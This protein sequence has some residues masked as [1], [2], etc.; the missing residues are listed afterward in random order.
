MNV[1][2]QVSRSQC[3]LRI[4]SFTAAEQESFGEFCTARPGRSAGRPSHV[5]GCRLREAGALS[6]RSVPQSGCDVPELIGHRGRELRDLY[7]N[8]L[9]PVQIEP[10]LWLKSPQNGN[11]SMNGQRLSALSADTSGNREFGDRLR[12]CKS[13]PLAGFS[14]VG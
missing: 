1:G 8:V 7:S 5:T 9:R 6:P 12:N 3:T 14:P 13:P 11:Y 2:A 4:P 10:S